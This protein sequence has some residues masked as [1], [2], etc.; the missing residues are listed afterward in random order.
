MRVRRG[1]LPEVSSLN[2]KD[3]TNFRTATTAPPRASY[4]RGGCE[5][6]RRAS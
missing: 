3:V 4:Q 2:A 1:E 5:V 6:C